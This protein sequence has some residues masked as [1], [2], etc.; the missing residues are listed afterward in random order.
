MSI[1]R[2]TMRTRQA[3]REVFINLLQKKSLNKISVSEITN[4]ANIGRGTFY[5][6]YEDVYSLYEQL[7]NELLENLVT[8]FHHAYPEKGSNNFMV[9]SQKLIDYIEENAS[10]FLL[11]IGQDN[12]GKM[13]QRLKKIFVDQVIEIEQIDKSD[14]TSIIETSFTVSGI[15]GVLTD[16]LMDGMNID[17]EY[18]TLIIN[19]LIQKC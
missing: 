17:K 15:V 12:E 9:L 8:L 16:W 3:I 19:V 5:L 7:V 6:H 4:A 18:L 13:N 14:F 1:D 11:L 10:L 2:R